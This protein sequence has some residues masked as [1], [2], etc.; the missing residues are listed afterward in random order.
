MTFT[1]MIPF[2]PWRPDMGSYRNDGNLVMAKNV[3]IQGTDYVP[4]KTLN[5]QTGAL[6]FNCNMPAEPSINCTRAH[7]RVH[8]A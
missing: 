2:G 7:L 1:D 8:F 6:R 5:E 4:F 3:L